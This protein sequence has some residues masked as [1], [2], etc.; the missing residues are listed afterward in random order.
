MTKS[1]CFSRSPAPSPATRTSPRALDDAKRSGIT[2]SGPGVGVGSS[3]NVLTPFERAFLER[4]F[5][6]VRGF[7][8]S[9]GGALG[10]HFGHRRSLDL[11]LFTSNDGSFRA[12]LA[13]LPAIA[14]GPRR[15]RP[16][17]AGGD[18]GG[19]RRERRDP[20]RLARVPGGPDDER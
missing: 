7:Y 10:L 6:S 5:G 20:D 8:L 3:R 14:A 1:G 17:V 12:P 16:G 2:S 18:R 19:R 13:S 15:R 11:H 4:L 9:G